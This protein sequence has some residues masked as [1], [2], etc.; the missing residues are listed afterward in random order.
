MNIVTPSIRLEVLTAEVSSGELLFNLL[1]D[2]YERRAT[3]VTTNLLCGA[4]GNA[5][6]RRDEAVS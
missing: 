5:E 3:V 2:R 6:L 1:T 4:D